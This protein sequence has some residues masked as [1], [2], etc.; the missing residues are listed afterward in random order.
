MK[1]VAMLVGALGLL[2]PAAAFAGTFSN[3]DSKSYEL[4]INS[5]GGGVHTSIGAN[6]TQMSTCGYFPCTITLKA[7]SASIKLTSSSQSLEIQNGQF[8]IK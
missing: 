5:S 6:T 8:R 4:Y 7:S 3:K 2:V 1:R